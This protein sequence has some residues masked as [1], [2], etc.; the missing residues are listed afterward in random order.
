MYLKVDF[1]KITPG[2]IM[3]WGLYLAGHLSHLMYRIFE[4]WFSNCV[5]IPTIPQL[6]LCPK[7]RDHFILNLLTWMII[8]SSLQVF[9]V[10]LWHLF[11]QGVSLLTNIFSHNSVLSFSKLQ[12][13]FWST[14]KFIRGKFSVLI[15]E[16]WCPGSHGSCWHINF[17]TQMSPLK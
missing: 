12:L 14:M 5:S 11:G 2:Q 3:C 17:G 15:C 7:L 16:V 10:S 4:R 13:C 1:V 9:K 6:Y 8:L